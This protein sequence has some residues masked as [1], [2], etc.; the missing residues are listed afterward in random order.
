MSKLVIQPS[1]SAVGQTHVEWQTFEEAENKRQM[2]GSQ[3]WDAWW[4]SFLWLMKFN[5]PY[6]HRVYKDAPKTPNT[7]PR[8]ACAWISTHNSVSAHPCLA[9]FTLSNQSLKCFSVQIQDKN[10]NSVHQQHEHYHQN[11]S[12]E[13]FPLSHH[14]PLQ[15]LSDSSGFWSFLV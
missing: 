8:P 11:V 5:L 15:N 14:R 7:G 3:V 10:T 12:L 9:N 4:G 6:L 2:Y 13:S 1:F